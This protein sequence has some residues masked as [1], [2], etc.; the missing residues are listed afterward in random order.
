MREMNILRSLESCLNRSMIKRLLIA[1]DVNNAVLDCSLF[2]FRE[3]PRLKY[4]SKIEKLVQFC[5]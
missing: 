3:K 1:Y 4:H 5:S 2:I